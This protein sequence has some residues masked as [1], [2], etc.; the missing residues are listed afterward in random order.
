MVYPHL[1]L[2]RDVPI[3]DRHRRQVRLRPFRPEDPRA[4]GSALRENLIQ[5]ERHIA[6]TDVGGYDARR[7]IKV[8]LRVGEYLPKLDDIPGVEVLSQEDKQAVLAFATEQG[9]REFEARLATLAREGNVAR[10]ELLFAIEGFDR[11]TPENRTGASLA[12]EGFPN[13][14]LFVLD[15]ELWPVE[16]APD[17]A[18]MLAAFVQWLTARGIELL[19][20]LSQPSLVLLK[21]RVTLPQ[22]DELLQ[23]RDVRTIDLPPRIGLTYAVLATGVGELVPSPPPPDGAPTLAVLDSGITQGHPVLAHA[24]GDVQGFVAPLR[25]SSDEPRI[26]HGT[27]VAALSLYGDLQ[28]RIENGP[29]IPQ[30]SLFAGKVFNNDRQDQTEFVERAVEEAVRYFHGQYGCRVFNLSYGDLRKRYEGRHLRGLAYTLDLLSRE[31]GVLFVVAAGN[32]DEIPLDARTSYPGYLFDESSKLIDPATALNAITVGGLAV[33]TAS[34][35]AQRYPERIEDVPIARELQP[36]PFTRTGPSIG[37]AI[38]PD[39]VEEAGNVAWVPLGRR[40]RHDGLGVLSAN[41]GFASE[42]PFAEFLGTSFAA[43]IVAHKAARLAA[44]FPEQSINFVRAALAV[45]AHWP[46]QTVQLL[47]SGGD[48][49]GRSRVLRAVGYGVIDEDALY[50]SSD[51]VVTL[52]SEETIDND[53]HHFYELPLP[54]EF[55]AGGRRVRTVSVALAHTPEVRTTRLDYKATKLAFNVVTEETLEAATRAF[56]HGRVDNLPER[57]TNRLIGEAERKGGTL[58]MSR[59]TFRVGINRGTKVFVVVTRRDA[60][61]SSGVDGREPYALAVSVSDVENANIRLHERVDALLQA[62]VQ[63]RERARTRAR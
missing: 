50:R 6:A 29:L 44:E 23:H 30:L 28:A 4:F 63:E 54:D 10:K 56:T 36:A 17:R 32:L 15:I 13:V 33:K 24:V 61:W 38:K 8:Q 27:A 12:R 53:K 60:N 18:E 26:G 21:V 49:E 57:S 19:D 9:L 35:D 7:L 22:A 42:R 1:V 2:S 31:L 5:A 11:W 51:H 45:H 58:Q 47:N 37:G 46:Q 25:D 41:S 14:P 43:P 39:F 48:A 3:T 34:R 55:W 16:S 62:R 52:Y 59:W 20:R 40:F